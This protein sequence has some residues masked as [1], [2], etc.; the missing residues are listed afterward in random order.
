M[1]DEKKIQIPLAKSKPR[2]TSPKNLIIFSKPKTGKTSAYAEL[3]NN[4]ILD[5]EDGTDYIE[6]MAVKIDTLADLKEVGKQI[7]EAG[8]PYEYVTVDTI[9]ALEK[10]TIPYAEQLYSNTL[11][12]KNWFKKN[13]DG[14][15]AADSGKAKYGNIVNMPEGAGYKWLWEAHTKVIE[16]IKSF[17]PKMI[18]SGHIKDVN[19]EKTSN[20]FASME[21][22]LSGKLKRIVT[23]TSDAIGYLYRKGNQNILSFKT[24]DEVA[25]GARPEHLSNQ[26]IVL[27]EKIDGKLMTYWDRVYPELAEKKEEEQVKSKKN[28]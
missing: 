18:Q 22:D 8:Y 17:A 13:P 15:L 16:F 9:T 14:S 26:E 3:P 23:S 25:C 20:T 21:L 12:G 19:L 7:K 10:I 2:T 5:F 4:L 6:G 11:P 1:T 27:S 28:K 24:T